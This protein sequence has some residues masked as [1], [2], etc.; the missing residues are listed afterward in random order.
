MYARK[1]ELQFPDEGGPAVV[2][3]CHDLTLCKST[4][5]HRG[6]DAEAMELY[7]KT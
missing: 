1:P 5:H 6:A 7:E 3:V 4:F 2:T